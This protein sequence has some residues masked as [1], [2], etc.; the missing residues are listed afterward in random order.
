VVLL[1]VSYWLLSRHLDRTLP[2]NDASEVLAEV[3]L[4]YLL[5]FLGTLLLTVAVAW[6][7]SGRALSPLKRIVRTARRVSDQRLEE[8]IEVTGPRDELR[9]A[10]ETLNAMLDR[11]EEAFDG[12]RR[13]IANASHELRSPMTVIRSEADIALSNPDAD[14]HEL[15]AALEAVVEAS[16]RSE[17]L[18]ESLLM[19]ARSQRGMLAREPT[20]LASAA[21]AAAAAAGAEAGARGLDLRVDARAARAL[22]DRRLLERLA[23]NLVDNAV[24][25]NRRGGV[26]EVTTEARNGRA[27]LRVENTGPVVSD[28]AARRL[29]EPFQRGSRGAS[30][31]GAGLGL[32]IVRSVTE[33]HGGWLRIA[34][35]PEG[36]LR[37]EVEVPASESEALGAT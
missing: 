1:G 33:A 24:R 27:V 11:L 3:R 25:Y 35:R 36:G 6:W 31:R 16:Q 18:L 26:V 12:Q 15:R 20:D 19:L 17:A 2:A 28:E 23:A 14:E 30:E 9:D 8:R 7:V 5:A 4:Q 10:A 13:F 37:V 22:G 29:A 32:S 21:R 34:P